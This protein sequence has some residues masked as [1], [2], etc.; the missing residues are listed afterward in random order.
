MSREI[1]R[2]TTEAGADERNATRVAWH[3]FQDP[4][5]SRGPPF[6]APLDHSLAEDLTPSAASSRLPPAGCVGALP[7]L[8][9]PHLT[10]T[11]MESE[12]RLI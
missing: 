3:R 2:A 10:K 5:M 9:P 7:G 4:R 8:V 12:Y 1:R 11:R 6:L